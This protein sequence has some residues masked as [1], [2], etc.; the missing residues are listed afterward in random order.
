MVEGPDDDH[1]FQALVNVLNLEVEIQIVRLQGRNNLRGQLKAVRLASRAEQSAFFS[2]GIALDCEEDPA[3]TAQ[4]IRH[5]LTDAELPAPSDVHIVEG[6]EP[7]VVYTLLPDSK[8]PG[9]LE[10]LCLRAFENDEAL[11]CV[12]DYIQCLTDLNA[13]LSVN[14]TSKAK[15]RTFLASKQ[16]AETRLGIAA[17]QN[18]WP[19]H[20]PAFNEVKTFLQLMSTNHD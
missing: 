3:A 18:W 16:K 17:R 6:S 19:W 8:T 20:D 7:Q 2:L 4:M 12:D 13:F 14:D 10:D 11:K 15:V 9:M 1:F 5:A